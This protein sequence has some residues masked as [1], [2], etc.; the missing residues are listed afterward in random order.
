LYLRLRGGDTLHQAPDG[1]LVGELAVPAGGHH[2]LV[3]EIS[4][5]PLEDPAPEP[6]ELWRTTVDAWRSAVPTLTGDAARDATF[7]Y[8]VLRGLTRPQ[9]GMVAAATTALPERALAGR[10]YD[11]RYA[12]VRDQC[13]AGRGIGA[14]VRTAG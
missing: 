5:R 6:A 13:R 9:G 2:D 3:L 7:A 11:Y 8:A 14:T 12:W 10:N 4:T 1:A